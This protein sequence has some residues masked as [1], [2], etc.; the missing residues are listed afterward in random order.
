MNRTVLLIIVALVLGDCAK[1]PS[2]NKTPTAGYLD[3]SERD[4]ALSGGV[5]MIPMLCST[6]GTKQT[7]RREQ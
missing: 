6:V 5:K 1:E 2:P 4:D 7:A 3:Y